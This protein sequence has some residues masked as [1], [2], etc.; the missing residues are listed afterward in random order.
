MNVYEGH[1]TALKKVVNDVLGENASK[2]LL[3][4]MHS[5]LDE[6]QTNPASLQNTCAKIEKMVGLF[7]GADKARLMNERFR[8]SFLK[9]GLPMR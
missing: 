3:S 2:M 1:S 5:M 7:H 6:D 4:R 9:A 8:N